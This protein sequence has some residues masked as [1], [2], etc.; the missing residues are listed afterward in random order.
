MFFIP[1]K[2]CIHGSECP[3]FNI[4]VT[5]MF[6]KRYA[7]QLRWLHPCVVR[8]R[9]RVQFPDKSYELDEHPGQGGGSLRSILSTRWLGWGLR[10]TTTTRVV[11]TSGSPFG[12]YP[13]AKGVV[14]VAIP[15]VRWV[16]PRRWNLFSSKF[17]QD[18]FWKKSF[19]ADSLPQ[20]DLV[21]S[22]SLSGS[23]LKNFAWFV[24]ASLICSFSELCRDRFWRIFPD[25]LL[26][27]W[28]GRFPSFARIDFE[29]FLPDSLLQVVFQAFVRID[30][31]EF[32]RF[33]IAGSILDFL[34]R[35]LG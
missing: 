20:S 9:A 26:Q 32:N 8:R 10:A 27:V 25:S 35:L 15:G 33:I 4:V 2:K 11:E 14:V 30:F 34:D 18:R 22:Q 1:Q 5:N 16:D 29:E 3:K 12:G 17:C 24:A 21:V 28:S 7:V 23:I 6:P 19:F 13:S 31:E